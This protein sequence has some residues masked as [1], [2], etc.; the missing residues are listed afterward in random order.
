MSLWCHD[1]WSVWKKAG[2][3]PEVAEEAGVA[4]GSTGEAFSPEIYLNCTVKEKLAEHTT[5]W[6]MARMLIETEKQFAAGK[7]DHARA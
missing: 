6:R 4:A 7:P 3:P 2:W 1:C 5:L